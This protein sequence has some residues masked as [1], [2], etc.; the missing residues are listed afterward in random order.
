[1]N[2]RLYALLYAGLFGAVSQAGGY[3]RLNGPYLRCLPWPARPASDAIEPLVHAMEA[4]APGPARA[5]ARARL[6]ELVEAWLDISAGERQVLTDLAAALPDPD[7]L[8]DVAG[9]RRDCVRPSPGSGHR[10]APGD[11]GLD[12]HGC[13]DGHA[14]PWEQRELSGHDQLGH[15]TEMGAGRR[16]VWGTTGS[17]EASNGA[18]VR[19]AQRDSSTRRPAGIC[20]AAP[21][22]GKWMINE[23]SRRTREGRARGLVRCARRRGTT[24]AGSPRASSSSTAARSVNSA[25]VVLTTSVLLAKGLPQSDCYVNILRSA[26]AVDT[27]DECGL[28]FGTTGGQV[29]ASNDSGDSWKAIATNLPAVFS[30][31]VQTLR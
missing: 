5:A 8:P 18:M 17:S 3:T 25:S 1:M 10:A 20:I 15:Q 16:G 7:K 28:Y 31:E 24:G 4:A 13:R 29:Y 21:M 12:H 6:D 14:N 30:V 19:C 26:L 11:P 23:T 2:S 22:A 27:L 9:Q